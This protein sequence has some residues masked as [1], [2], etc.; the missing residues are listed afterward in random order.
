M[1]NFIGA[2]FDDPFKNIPSSVT[3]LPAFK[4]S[5]IKS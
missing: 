3:K 1:K 5:Q 4:D 2:L